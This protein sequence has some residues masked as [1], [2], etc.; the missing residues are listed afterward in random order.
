M[1]I[2]KE[3]I[4]KLKTDL[5][6]LHKD[7]ALALDHLEFHLGVKRMDE[8]DIHRMQKHLKKM[9]EDMSNLIEHTGLL[10]EQQE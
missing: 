2:I 6:N 10:E 4:T 9:D 8:N 1:G 7:V 5:Q 3:D